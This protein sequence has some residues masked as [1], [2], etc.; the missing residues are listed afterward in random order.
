[1]LEYLKQFEIVF[2]ILL[3]WLLGLLTGIAERIRGSYRRR[4]LIHA[5]VDE[6]LDLRHTMA[7]V[8]FR[9]RAR[10]AEVSDAFLDKILPIVEAYHGPDRTEDFIEGL[11]KT[12][13]LPETERAAAHQ[14][15]RKPNVGLAL[16]QYAIPLFATQIA[17][18]SICGLDF[19]RSCSEFDTTSI[20]ITSSCLTRYRYLRRPSTIPLLWIWQLLLLTRNRDTATP[21]HA[22]KSLC[23]R[24]VTSRNDT[25]PLSDAAECGVQFG[26]W[27][28]RGRLRAGLRDDPKQGRFNSTWTGCT[29]HAAMPVAMAKA[30]QIA[31]HPF[32][33]I[34]ES[35]MLAGRCPRQCSGLDCSDRLARTG[36]SC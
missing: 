9:I 35:Q 17:D 27:L 18:L 13:S 10:Y 16:R 21:A 29:R 6:M 4:D 36:S 31:T 24:L 32:A 28:P 34:P 26:D 3:G 23:R 7:I 12:R 30:R 2:T 8:A 11:R 15:L 5:V 33:L 20:S 19:Q 25:G 14:I 1:M 22:P